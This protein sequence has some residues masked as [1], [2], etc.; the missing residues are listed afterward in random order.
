MSTLEAL[1]AAAERGAPPAPDGGLT[2]V[3]QPSPRDLGVIAFT[4]HTVVFADLPPAWVRERLPAGDLSAPVNPP[5]L[6]ELGLRTGRSAG[7]LDL[8]AVAGPL[9]GPPPLAL[10]EVTASGH[11]RVERALAYRDEVRVWTCEGGLLT[12]GRGVAGRWEAAVEVEPGHRGRG[13]GRLLATAARHLAARPLWAQ[14]APG[15]AASVRAFLAAG[16]V[17]IGSEVLL[18]PR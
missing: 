3:A 14:I 17:P 13:L 11:P 6:L 12:V 7:N 18:I 1:L 10:R 15:N 5:F 2:V 9:P 8:L 16:Y 4:G